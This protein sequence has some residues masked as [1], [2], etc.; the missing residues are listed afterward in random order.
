MGGAYPTG[1]YHPPCCSLN[2]RLLWQPHWCVP[3]PVPKGVRTPRCQFPEAPR[4]RCSPCGASP[5]LTGVRLLGVLPIVLSGTIAGAVCTLAFWYCFA[6]LRSVHNQDG[7]CGARSKLDCDGTAWPQWTKFFFTARVLAWPWWALVLRGA[8]CCRFDSN[9]MGLLF[10]T[11]R[12][13][14]AVRSMPGC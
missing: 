8:Q 12:T 13:S 2:W 3:P 1:A 11:A 10:T 9:S 4:L 5:N 7:P 6:G 14:V